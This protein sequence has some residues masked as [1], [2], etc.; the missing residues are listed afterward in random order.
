MG[1]AF[2]VVV[3]KS[4]PCTA[5]WAAWF[6]PFWD[7]DEETGEMSISTVEGGVAEI[8]AARVEI[9]G[10][11]P[12]VL[13]EGESWWLPCSDADFAA[14]EVAYGDEHDLRNRIFPDRA[15]A[16]EHVREVL[17]RFAHPQPWESF[18]R[19]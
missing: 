6:M 7:E 8:T 17:H 9:I 1:E 11:A 4:V 19:L 2:E 12:C 10:G 3:S 5:G 14:E 15:S 16:T 13:P 18:I